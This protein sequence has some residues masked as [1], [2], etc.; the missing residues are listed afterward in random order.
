MGGV[1]DIL[2]ADSLFHGFVETDVMAMGDGGRLTIMDTWFFNYG[3]SDV[4]IDNEEGETV[5][6]KVIDMNCSTKV[7]V[8]F[9][10]ATKP[11]GRHWEKQVLD[12]FKG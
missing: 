3:S 11:L 4:V 1:D 5:S 2:H 6:G 12:L 9:S 7:R 8:L 10:R